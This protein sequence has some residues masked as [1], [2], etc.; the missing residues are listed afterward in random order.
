MIDLDLTRE[1]LITE[2][3]KAR[4]QITALQRQLLEFQQVDVAYPEMLLKAVPE[5]ILL[6]DRDGVIAEYKP[7]EEE[8]LRSSLPVEKMLGHRYVDMFPPQF[9]Q[10]LSEALMRGRR[11][12]KVISVD[13][14]MDLPGEGP[15]P[16]QAWI[17]TFPGGSSAC[18]IR[19]LPET[20]RDLPADPPAA[21][22]QADVVLER[23]RAQIQA[24]VT[25]EAAMQAAVDALSLALDGQPVK[26]E[27]D[28]G[29][30]STET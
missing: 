2:L 6:F 27:F 24:A 13:F 26:A 25:V 30:P 11:A 7:A 23:I 28:P 17:K 16:L 8:P 5:L 1:Q 20:S 29:P 19:C 22:A 14:T 15:T 21:E 10:A 3:M 12:S 9:S 4:E 18:A